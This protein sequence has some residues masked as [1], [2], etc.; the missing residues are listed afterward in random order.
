MVKAKKP[1]A[2]SITRTR[3][4]SK[5]ITA[6]N[7]H[8]AHNYYQQNKCRVRDKAVAHKLLYTHSYTQ[9]HTNACRL[10]CRDTDRCDCTKTTNQHR[11][12]LSTS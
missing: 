12:D 11:A 10:F 3:L 6:Y 5:K 4:N 8:R 9:M 7:R 1:K 2:T